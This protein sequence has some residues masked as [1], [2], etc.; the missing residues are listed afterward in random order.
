MAR[1]PY[2]D[3]ILISDIKRDSVQFGMWYYYNKFWNHDNDIISLLLW[4]GVGLM[5]ARGE[6]AEGRGGMG[7]GGRSHSLRF[8]YA[9][10]CSCLDDFSR[11][12]WIVAFFSIS[13]H[14]HMHA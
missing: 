14:M 13:M 11:S 3:C 10:I 7:D 9:C 2:D 12:G 4:G 1:I 5:R 6:G 8:A